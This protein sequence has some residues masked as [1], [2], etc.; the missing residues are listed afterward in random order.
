MR[1]S[2]LHK[3]I[4]NN[5]DG[6]TVFRYIEDMKPVVAEHRGSTMTIMLNRPELLNS[7]NHEMV[8]LLT[9]YFNEAASLDEVHCVVLA[10]NS[11]R[12]FCA[13]GDVKAVIRLVHEGAVEDAVQFFSDEYDLDRLIHR[14]PKPVVIIADGITMGGGLGLAAGADLIIATENTVMAMPETRIGF[15]PDVGA[16][17][18]LF[19]KC[20]PGY[21]E[22]LGLTGYEMRGRECVRLG[23]ATHFIRR[24]RLRDLMHSLNSTRD[25]DGENWNTLENLKRIVE[26]FDADEVPANREMDE[27][28]ASYFSNRRSVSEILSGLSSCSTQEKLCA[29]VYERLS[30]R[31]P[32]AVVLTLQLLRRN[33]G[34]PLD[35]V[36]A[37][38]LKAARYS[39]QHHDYREGIR[40]RIIDKDDTPRWKPVHFEEV[41][42]TGLDW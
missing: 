29:G 2:E 31:S 33:E 42:L 1:L 7:L 17:G 40:A 25:D 32:T 37:A 9:D 4:M 15:F 36:L 3:V 14:F 5:L 18:W 10:G 22:F 11:E 26:E 28:V 27:W 13:G 35:E 21:P 39:I 24:D 41:Q 12:A 23:L 34:R 20:P 6:R 38:E 19:E 30:E 8:R 16:T